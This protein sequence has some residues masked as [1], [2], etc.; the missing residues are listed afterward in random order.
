MVMNHHHV[1]VI[2]YLTCNLRH[3]IINYSL[4]HQTEFVGILIWTLTIHQ[5]IHN[6]I[7]YRLLWIPDA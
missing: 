2:T 4:I 3:I 1:D 7:F 6:L 5:L